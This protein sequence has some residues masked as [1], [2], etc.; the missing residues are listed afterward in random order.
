MSADPAVPSAGWFEGREHRLAVRI[1]YEDTDFTGVVYHANYVRYFERGRSDFLRLAG[2]SHSDLLAR[3]DPAAFVITRLELD[4]KTPA[5][6]DDALIVVTTYDRVRGPRLFI[7]QKILRDATLIA[8]A[9]VEAACISLD[10]RPRKPP[11]GMV[12]RLSP[13]FEP[14]TP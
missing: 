8:Q 13:W 6:I 9:A 11:A 4:F 10:G 14:A 3:D 7:S 5:R 12:E 1:Y 2:V